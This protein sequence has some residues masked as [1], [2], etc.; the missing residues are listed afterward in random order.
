MES[1]NVFDVYLT[2][3]GVD[4]RSLIC[5]DAI[6]PPVMCTEYVESLPLERKSITYVPQ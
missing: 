6:A 2:L 3:E 1:K 4:F 5:D